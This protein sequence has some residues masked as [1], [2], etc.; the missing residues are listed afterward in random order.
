VKG[1]L[2][3]G[4]ILAALAVA[5]LL[6]AG[7]A[8]G[9]TRLAEGPRA[10]P[11]HPGAPFDGR[12]AYA[13]TKLQLSFG[14]RP[15]GSAAQRAAAARLVELL[16][17]GR[18]EAVPGGLRNVVGELT[19]RKPA[20]VV[21]AHY[22]TTDVPG[23]LGANN[24]AAGVGAVV[25]LARAMRSDRAVPGR[26]AV[27]FVLFDGEEAPTGYKDFYAEGLRGSKAYAAAHSRETREVIVLDFIALHGV[28]LRRDLSSSPGLWSR[29]R[30]AAARTGTSD[31]FPG[32]VQGE[33]L[34]DHTPF[35]RAGVPAIDLIDFDYS[36]WQK[37]CDDLSR[38]SQTS[39][40]KVGA[41]V[42]ELL[43]AERLRPAG[44]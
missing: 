35:L 38:V 32:L 18:F 26:A 22:D 3:P 13:V 41:T 10:P 33:V 5:G 42:L 1:R 29:L 31:L 40:T 6:A 43:R 8:V 24:S 9:G 27:R 30:A 36:C 14:P 23:Y 17:R 28:Q 34:D 11:P 16:P 20:I 7:S 21:A 44:G 4:C 37:V 12:H 19:G 39:L 15:A 25:A 2:R